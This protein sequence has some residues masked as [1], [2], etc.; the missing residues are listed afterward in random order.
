M[1]RKL[2]LCSPTFALPLSC[3]LPLCLS[4]CRELL[5]EFKDRKPNALVQVA[6]LDA[7]EQ[8]IITYACTEVVEVRIPTYTLT[9]YELTRDFKYKPGLGNRWATVI[10]H[11]P[12]KE[13]NTWE[14]AV[15]GK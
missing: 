7:H 9:Q 10:K 11:I 4:A 5:A 2:L 1:F 12:H 14:H 15:I 8:G 6:V 3:F 13:S